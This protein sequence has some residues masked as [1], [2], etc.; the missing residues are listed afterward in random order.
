MDKINDYQADVP[1]N[2]NDTIDNITGTV[3]TNTTNIDVKTAISGGGGS[4]TVK[5]PLPVE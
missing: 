1:E 5:A 3:G 2:H 4:E